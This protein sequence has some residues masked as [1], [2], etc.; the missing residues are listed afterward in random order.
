MVILTMEIEKGA[1]ARFFAYRTGRFVGLFVCLNSIH[2]KMKKR[3]QRH[4][5]HR[6]IKAMRVLVAL[7]GGIDSSVV[8]YLLKRAGHELVAV[9]FLLWTDPLAPALAEILPSKCCTT[10]NAMRAQKVAETLSIPYHIVD[11]SEEF[12]SSVVDPYLESHRK[13]LTPNPCIGCNR[14]IKFGKLIEL[15]REYGCEKLATGHYA[16]VAV[17]ESASA[18]EV[19][20]APLRRCLLLE[21]VDKTKDQSYYLYGLSQEQLSHCLFP[22]GAMQKSQVYGLAKEFGVPFDDISYRESQDLCFF[23]E[24]TPEEFLKRHLSDALK[25]GPIVRRDGTVMGTHEGLALYTLGQR[26]GLGIGGLKIPLEVVEKR[27]QENAL[28]V[29]DRGSEQVNDVTIG[30]IAWVSWKPEESLEAPFE[31]RTRS[32]STKHRGVL[33]YSGTKGVF[34]LTTPL[35]PQSP[36]QALVLYRGEEIVGGG[37]IQ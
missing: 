22:L 3:F 12:K 8:A 20:E 11:L 34:R 24:K 13:G 10:Q 18:A 15:M 31:C 37:I 36:G 21:A 25:P 27:T 7:S 29:A 35:P 28:V 23:P 32:L 26:K 5:E 9:R 6:T 2:E 33:S 1:F 16:R 30:D 17:E 14:T 19:H 4:S